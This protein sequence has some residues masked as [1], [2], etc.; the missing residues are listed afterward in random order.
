[1]AGR[2]SFAP[3]EE[4]VVVNPGSRK[5]IRIAGPKMRKRVSMYCPQVALYRQGCE[6]REFGYPVLAPTGT[7]R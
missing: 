5:K 2:N 7:V 1:M 3:L 6:A 4:T